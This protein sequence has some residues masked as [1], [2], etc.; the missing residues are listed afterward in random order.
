MGTPADLR[1]DTAVTARSSDDAPFGPGALYESHVPAHWN[2][3][4]PSGGVVMATAL[5]AVTRELAAGYALLSAHAIF[6]EP[7]PVG[8]V[9]VRVR[10]L[11]RG[12]LAQQ[13]RAELFFPKPDTPSAWTLGLE[14]VATVGVAHEGPEVQA[15]SFPEAVLDF[16]AAQPL[17]D[18]RAGPAPFFQN[19]EGRLALGPSYWKPYEPSEARVARWHRYLVPPMVD[20]RLDPLAL[21][22]VADTMPQAL[23]NHLG[24]EGRRFHAPSL[25]LTLHFLRA[26][27]TA[28]LLT[29]CHARSAAS[30]FATADVEVWDAHGQLVAFGTQMMILRPRKP[31][32]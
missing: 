21:L 6:C 4:Y 28:C 22:P 16:E 30:G 20:G 24:S 12:R 27:D 29:H 15:V 7:V 14:V 25:D 1:D 8:A 3:W 10:P 2:Y 23:F 5:R 31:R 13:W 19:F 11:R 17:F 9:R 26:T 32:P 18:G